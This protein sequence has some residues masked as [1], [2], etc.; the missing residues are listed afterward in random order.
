MSDYLTRQAS[1][2]QILIYNDSLP[3]P[4][5]NPG[6]AGPS[7][8]HPKGLPITPVV[9]QP[10]IKPGSVVM[11]TST[12]M[13]CLRLLRHSGSLKVTNQMYMPI[14]AFFCCQMMS[15]LMDGMLLTFFKNP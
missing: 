1:E 8:R 14:E 2:E 7:V 6:D 13:Q 4:N 15:G 12:D 5:P 3:R 9:I 11:P 10:G